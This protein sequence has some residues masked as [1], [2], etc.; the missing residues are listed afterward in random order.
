MPTVV[1]AISCAISGYVYTYKVSTETQ[2]CFLSYSPSAF[3]GRNFIS[4]LL[5]G[6]FC[7]ETQ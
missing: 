1:K 4:A 5:I 2:V 7:L 6:R 3:F